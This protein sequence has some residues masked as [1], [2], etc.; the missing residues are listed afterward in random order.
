MEHFEISQPIFI[1]LNGPHYI[2][3][4]HAMTIFLQAHRVWHL[5]IG[6]VTAPTQKKDESEEDFANR[7]KD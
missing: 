2:H 3:W 5:I 7:E 1:I 4:A 6:E